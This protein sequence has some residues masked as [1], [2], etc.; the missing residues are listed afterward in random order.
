M[1]EAVEMTEAELESRLPTLFDELEDD[2][3]DK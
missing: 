2:E 1:E 3:E